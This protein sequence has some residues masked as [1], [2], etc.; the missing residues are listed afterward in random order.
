MRGGARA[1][2]DRTVSSASKNRYVAFAFARGDVLLEIDRQG[3]IVFA[4]GTVRGFFGID[5]DALIGKTLGTMVAKESAP[6]LQT[7]LTAAQTGRRTQVDIVL[8]IG[9]RRIAGNLAGCPLPEASG[10]YLSFSAQ[11]ATRMPTEQP[12]DA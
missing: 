11:L 1:R 5:A 8:Q 6:A 4:T 3:A 10:Y 9:A 12:R 7:V 2:S